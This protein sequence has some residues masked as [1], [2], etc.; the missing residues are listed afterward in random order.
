S[1]IV[2]ACAQRYVGM[3][4]GLHRR[5]CWRAHLTR[6]SPR[7]STVKLTT[8]LGRSKTS[9][10]ALAGAVAT[11]LL[12]ACGTTTEPTSK[13]D[14]KID[15]TMTLVTVGRPLLLAGDTVPVTLRT[16]NAAG[17]PLTA[18]GATVVFSTQGGSSAGAF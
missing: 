8:A 3:S 16:R 4:T 5:D 18:G 13:P 9:S 15:P 6:H 17:Q 11:V 7:G 12:Q 10:I 2:V 1:W 14:T